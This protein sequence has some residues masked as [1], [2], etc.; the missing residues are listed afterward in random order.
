M[1]LMI[2]LSGAHALADQVVVYPDKDTRIT[3]NHP[4]RDDGLNPRI[5]VQKWEKQK[6]YLTG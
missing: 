5:Y 3:R 1:T 2:G 6:G 4:G